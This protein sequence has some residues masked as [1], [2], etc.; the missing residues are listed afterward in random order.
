VS[1]ANVG[2]EH[3]LAFIGGGHQ[4]RRM[5]LKRCRS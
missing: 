2:T 3:P 5:P 4:P 1:N